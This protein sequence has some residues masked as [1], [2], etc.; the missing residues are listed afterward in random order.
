MNIGKFIAFEGID[1]SG[2]STQFNILIKRLE[3]LGVKC[4]GTKEPTDSFIGSLIR[5]ILRGEIEA[6][7]RVLANLFAADRADHLLNETDGI[8]HKIKSGISVITDR[9]YFSSYAFKGVDLDMDWVIKVNEV[10]YNILRP[11]VTIFLDIPVETA[12][13]RIKSRQLHAELFETEER[14]KLTREKYFEAFEKLKDAERVAVINA[15]ADIN[16]IADKIWEEVGTL[17]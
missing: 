15:D 6:D 12:M 3:E 2:K 17:F 4:Y 11:D 7:K 14:L 16:I 9:Y 1:G 13:Q 10:N 8:Y 5:Q